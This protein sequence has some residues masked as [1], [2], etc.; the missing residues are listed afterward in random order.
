MKAAFVMAPSFSRMLPMCPVLPHTVSRNSSPCLSRSKW[1]GTFGWPEAGSTSV[2]LSPYL[3][4]YWARPGSRARRTAA[5][6]RGERT[7]KRTMPQMADGCS[8]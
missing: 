7:E 2:V 1:R 3:A 6:S 8:P 4:M 5:S